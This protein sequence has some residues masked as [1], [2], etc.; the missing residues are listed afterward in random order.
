[1]RTLV[2]RFLLTVVIAA[3]TFFAAAATT[4]TREPKIY[5]YEPHIETLKGILRTRMYP[6]PPGYESVKKGDEVEHIWLVKLKNPIT[7][8]G[9]AD[10]TSQ[11]EKETGIKEIQLIVIDEKIE[12]KLRKLMGHNIRFTGILT[13]AITGHHHLPI[14]MEVKGF[15]V[16]K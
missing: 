3:S 12:K 2:R 9:A 14:L 11:N 5:H 16:E 13:H 7:V 8:T 6:G 1:M 10:P 15:K 4:R